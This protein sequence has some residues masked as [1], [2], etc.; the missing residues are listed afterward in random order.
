MRKYTTILFDMDGVL[1][2]SES[3]YMEQLIQFFQLNRIHFK[4]EELYYIIGNSPKNYEKFVR[5]TWAGSRNI[6]EY[7]KAYQEFEKQYGK[8]DYKKILFPNT[9]STLKRLVK[10]G[11]KTGLASS[12]P[13]RNVKCMLEECGLNE[14][15]PYYLTSDDV[16]ET[17]PNPQIYIDLMKLLSVNKEE[18]LIVEDSY[19][20]I[21]AGKKAGADVAAI[22]NHDFPQ[23]QSRADY[24]IEDI[25]D[26][27][28]LL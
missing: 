7:E 11:Y 25:A 23:D 10:D 3:L 17:K 18:V 13:C 5:S 2:D 4:K 19:Y 26:I 16:E 8:E 20:G 28:M 27:F 6:S 12:S 14:Y 24:I 9:L 22:K 21:T 1:I 15:I